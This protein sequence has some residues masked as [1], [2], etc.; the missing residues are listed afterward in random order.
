MNRYEWQTNRRERAPRGPR[1]NRRA[2]R[3]RS[4]SPAPET[5]SRPTV[6]PLPGGPRPIRPGA[7]LMVVGVMSD[8]PALIAQW[9]DPR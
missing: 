9:V 6:I 5:P 3:I 4:E 7:R 1:P 8:Y 2:P